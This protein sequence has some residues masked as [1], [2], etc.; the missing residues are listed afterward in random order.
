MWILSKGMHH[1]PFEFEV[2]AFVTRHAGMPMMMWHAGVTITKDHNTLEHVVGF[3]LVVWKSAVGND[4]VV[5][6]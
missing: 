6:G 2:E 4:Q 3:P 1:L 5:H